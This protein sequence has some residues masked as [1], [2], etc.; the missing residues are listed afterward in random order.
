MVRLTSSSRTLENRGRSRSAEEITSTILA[1]ADTNEGATKMQIMANA[2][3]T[4]ETATGYLEKLKRG[5]LIG[6]S[7][8][9]GTYMTTTKGRKIIITAENSKQDFS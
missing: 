2:F 6:Y 8:G 4:Y 5:G 3:V 1:I 7:P 9:T